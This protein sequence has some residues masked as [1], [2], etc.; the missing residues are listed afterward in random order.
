ME[1]SRE[2]LQFL[3]SCNRKCMKRVLTEDKSGVYH[4]NPRRSLWIE[5]DEDPPPKPSSQLDLRRS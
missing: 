4:R 5:K 3:Q 2:H 1:V